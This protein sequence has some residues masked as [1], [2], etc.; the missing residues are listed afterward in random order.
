MTNDK[1][2]GKGKNTIKSG[3]GTFDIATPNDSQSNFEPELVKKRQTILVDNLSDK[4]I[5]DVKA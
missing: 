3:F 4:I 2:N 5:P 1:R